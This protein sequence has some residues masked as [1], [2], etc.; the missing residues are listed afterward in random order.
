MYL[1]LCPVMALMSARHGF[2][3]LDGMGLGYLAV[4]AILMALRV[5]VL[6]I[7]PACLVYRLV[8]AAVARLPGGGR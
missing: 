1:V 3:S 6:V 5:I 7:V 4:A 8:V 2:G